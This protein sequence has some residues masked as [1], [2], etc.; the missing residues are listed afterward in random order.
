MFEGVIGFDGFKVER[1]SYVSTNKVTKIDRK[2]LSPQ[3]MIYLV[4]SSRDQNYFNILLGVRVGFNE[5]NFPFTGEV[6]IRGYYHFVPRELS[7]IQIENYQKFK[8]IN[9]SAIL[10]P[11]LRS[12]LSDLTGK[13]VHNSILLPTINFQKFIESKD[14]KDLIL[15]SEEYEEYEEYSGVDS[16]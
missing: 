16:H 7:E 11:Y 2:E 5:E 14:L 10:F 6:V 12:I 9:G 13:S 8:L 1:M 4:D 3:F 15:N